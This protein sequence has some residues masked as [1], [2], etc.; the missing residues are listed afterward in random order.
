[1]SSDSE[2]R[3]LE[4]VDRSHLVWFSCLLDITYPYGIDLGPGVSFPGVCSTIDVAVIVFARLIVSEPPG[5]GTRATFGG[6][7]F[8][9]R[10]FP[11]LASFCLPIPVA[12][13]VI[14][15]VAVVS[16][17]LAVGLTGVWYACR[18]C[19]VAVEN[20][21]EGGVLLDRRVGYSLCKEVC[22]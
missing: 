3:G 14:S 19:T 16:K 1:M 13:A 18:V 4:C 9:F 15:F 20:R 5:Q 17:F 6:P 7:N 8:L 12:L 10:C 11:F 2:R 22:F 21:C